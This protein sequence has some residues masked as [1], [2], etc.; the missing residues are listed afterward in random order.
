MLGCF[1]VQVC[2]NDYWS[3]AF[4]SKLL[5]EAELS[6]LHAK[7]SE[8][9]SENAALKKKNSLLVIANQILK[10]GDTSS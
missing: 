2:A 1:L 9:T 5:R 8:L 10:E 7:I 3:Q 4:A 6:S